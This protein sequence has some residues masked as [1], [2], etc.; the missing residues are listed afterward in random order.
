MV[1]KWKR[2]KKFLEESRRQN[3]RKILGDSVTHRNIKLLFQRYIL[4]LSK[5]WRNSL[6]YPILIYFLFFILSD[7]QSLW[8]L[9]TTET[10]IDKFLI[11]EIC[12][13]DRLQIHFLYWTPLTKKKSNIHEIRFLLE[14]YQEIFLTMMN[15]TFY[16][17]M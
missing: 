1:N 17:H 12:R 11:R 6:F 10:F 7:S 8:D 4:F 13:T 9:L 14:F 3:N 15:T 2:R 5:E 16:V